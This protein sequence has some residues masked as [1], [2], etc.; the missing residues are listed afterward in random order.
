MIPLG[1]HADD[2]AFIISLAA[3]ITLLAMVLGMLSWVMPYDIDELDQLHTAYLYSQGM[4]PIIHFIDHPLIQCYKWTL[5][6]LIPVVG[7]GSII[8]FRWLSVVLGLFALGVFAFTVRKIMGTAS[9]IFAAGFLGI[10]LP[11]LYRIHQMRSDAFGL[12]FL[13]ISVAFLAGV[14]CRKTKLALVGAGIFAGLAT[15]YRPSLVA[16]PFAAALV[17]LFF[18][19]ILP[20]ILRLKRAFVFA[21][22]AA[23]AGAVL[24][25]I[26]Y[27]LSTILSLQP[28]IIAVRAI[29]LQEDA[30]ASSEG[31]WRVGVGG[32]ILL[33]AAAFGLVHFLGSSLVAHSKKQNLCAQCLLATV[34]SYCLV[35][36][37][38]KLCFAQ[39]ILF[40]MF[41][42]SPFV[43][44][45]IERISF[46][47]RYTS[48]RRIA[49]LLISALL[50]LVTANSLAL[51]NDIYGEAHRIMPPV[52]EVVFRN[53][54]SDDLDSIIPMREKMFVLAPVIHRTLGVESLNAPAHIKATKDFFERVAR[55]DEY[56]FSSDSSHL[57][58]LNPPSFT[59]PTLVH[60]TIWTPGAFD[61]WIEFYDANSQ[62][63][64][65][66]MRKHGMLIWGSTGLNSDKRI[67]L[68]FENTTP[69]IIL[70]DSVFFS[71]MERYPSLKKFIGDNY[72]AVYLPSAMRFFGIH[73]ILGADVLRHWRT[74]QTQE[75]A[76]AFSP[77]RGDE[78]IIKETDIGVDD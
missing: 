6:L 5:G 17:L 69:V 65:P 32:A 77:L 36:F 15:A 27:R 53:L 1:D 68:E 25:V 42:A 64:Q 4:K 47:G 52:K 60:H 11:F 73:R 10:S 13:S 55:E 39:D 41:F 48:R 22:A 74:A 9:A 43:G 3:F 19:K 29:L 20:K 63:M 78:K 14:L 75:T 2:K 67:V 62:F 40:L 49:G 35:I 61:R 46:Y 56:C 31:F 33:L 54:F 44:L 76:N 51:L 57:F 23:A 71:F 59:P 7:D 72:E 8:V 30:A 58:R 38:R 37:T 66:S 21:T 24:F 50:A 70:L 16:Y 12:A 26:P 45:L 28:L 34:F 18:P